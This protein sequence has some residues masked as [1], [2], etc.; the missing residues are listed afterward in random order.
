MPVPHRAEPSRV[1]CACCET[2]SPQRFQLLFSLWGWDQLSP[3]VL[4]TPHREALHWG[5]GKTA[6]PAKRV[7]LATRVAPLLGISQSVSNKNLSESAAYKATDESD[8]QTTIMKG[9]EACEPGLCKKIQTGNSHSIFIR[10]RFHIKKPLSLLISKKQLLTHSSFMDPIQN[11]IL[12]PPHL[13]FFEVKSHSV[14]QSGVQW[15]DLGSLQPL[16]SGDRVSPYW[17]GWFPNPDLVICPSWPPKVPGSQAGATMPGYH[18]LGLNI[19][20]RLELV[21]LAHCNLC[22][23]G[24]NCTRI[25]TPASGEG[26]K[27]LPLVAE[28]E[29][30]LV[31]AEITWIERSRQEREKGEWSLTVL[32]RPECSG[33]I[34]AH[35]S[36][37]VLGSSSAAASA[38]C[39]AVITGAGH[40]AQLIFVFLAKTSFHHVGQ[41]GLEILTSGILPA[42][43]FQTA[44]IPGTSHF[45]WLLMNSRIVAQ[46]GVQGR[47]LGSLQS[48]PPRFKPGDSRRRSHA[49]RRRDSFGRRG[50]FAGTQRGASQ[51]GVCGTDGDRLG[52]SHP[53]K[54]NS[55]WKR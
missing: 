6:A 45:A 22:L 23:L 47:N 26:L 13:F 34:S 40:H 18:I 5:A 50:S 1:R 30:E 16:P 35:C 20:S 41:A 55:N 8:M 54:E 49:G 38:S 9:K 53:H 3:S 4:Y 14:T 36:L 17:P 10:S 46:A 7:A 51:C 44:G 24:S 12:P 25:T 29:G 52:W 19:T 28:R 42:L 32:P 39:L 21:A 15:H 43:A 2:L 48:P 31:C 27:L 37:P 11:T 33:A